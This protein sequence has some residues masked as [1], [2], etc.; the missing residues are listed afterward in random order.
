MR[1]EQNPIRNETSLPTRVTEGGS[2][3]TAI[4]AS[5]V[6]ISRR[7]RSVF[8]QLQSHLSKAS[9]IKKAILQ[10]QQLPIGNEG[11][12]KHLDESFQHPVATK[13][14]LLDR[15]SSSLAPIQSREDGGSRDTSHDQDGVDRIMAPDHMDIIHGSRTTTTPALNKVV[16]ATG[17]VSKT[18]RE[19]MLQ[20]LNVANQSGN[21]DLKPKQRFNGIDGV[22]ATVKSPTLTSP[23]SSPSTTSASSL[24]R[25]ADSTQAS[26]CT[27]RARLLTKLENERRVRDGTVSASA[28]PV[29][30]NGATPPHPG[31]KIHSSNSSSSHSDSALEAKLRSQAL[32]RARLA[33]EKKKIDNPGNQ[34][35]ACADEDEGKRSSLESSE[36]ELRLKI[37]LRK[38]RG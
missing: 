32:L 20:W 2:I 27:L 25:S 16:H 23:P 30:N 15:L 26:S 11:P 1:I 35:Q 31:D 36:R 14:S 21:R 4:D 34:S 5:H 24:Q 29:T 37:Q 6:S 18:T 17:Q 22:S 28:A 33:V 10:G 19:T 3:S 7:P 9:D 13:P 8:D 12:E 38:A